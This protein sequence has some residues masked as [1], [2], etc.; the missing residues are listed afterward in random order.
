MRRIVMSSLRGAGICLGFDLA[1][2][3]DTWARTTDLDYQLV[4]QHGIDAVI[5]PMPAISIREFWESAFKDHGATWND[6]I[7]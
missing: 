7:L 1:P 2:A 5:W 4:Y 6:I 3:M